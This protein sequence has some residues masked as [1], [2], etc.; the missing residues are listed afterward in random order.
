MQDC[1]PIGA[2]DDEGIGGAPEE[3]E[4]EEASQTLQSVRKAQRLAGG[5]NWLATRSRP[6][7]AF[8][9]SQVSSAA[10][11]QPER[12]IALGKR[13]LRYL[14][15]TRNHGVALFPTGNPDS[16]GSR[17]PRELQ[18]FGD[19]SYEEGWAQTGVV[20]TLG[21]VASSWTSTKQ[22]Q[23]PRS[24]AESEVTA[25]AYAGHTMEGVKGLYESIGHPTEASHFA[26]R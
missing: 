2:L 9:V 21:G 10:T 14:A 8:V 15:G 18:C 4:S 17:E 25:M 3:E 23:A 5:L 7:I 12:A 24:T 19:A 16:P 20:I 6:D 1:N 11:K 26:L 22:A 13:C